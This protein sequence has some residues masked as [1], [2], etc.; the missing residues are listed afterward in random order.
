MSGLPPRSVKSPRQ[1]EPARRPRRSLRARP[2]KARPRAVRRK[3]AASPRKASRARRREPVPGSPRSAQTRQTPR[4]ARPLQAWFPKAWSP[5]PRFLRDLVAQGVVS[6][7]QV[8]GSVSQAATSPDLVSQ[9]PVSGD[10]GAGDTTRK[11]SSR[12]TK[13]NRR[14]N[15]PETRC[16]FGRD[17]HRLVASRERDER[18]RRRIERDCHQSA[19]RGPLVRSPKPAISDLLGD[20][21]RAARANQRLR[22]APD[23]LCQRSGHFYRGVVADLGGDNRAAGRWRTCPGARGAGSDFSGR[24]GRDRFDRPDFACF[25]AR[26]RRSRS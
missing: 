16:A 21:Q 15:R 3:A 26:R 22:A 7:A 5:R 23:S 18:D 9:L 6:Q 24:G 20:D 8:Q 10:S 12:P 13:S 1:G 19:D 17:R 25:V 14:S 4:K 2:R 11:G